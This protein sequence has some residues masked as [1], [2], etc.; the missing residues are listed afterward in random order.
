METTKLPLQG[1]LKNYADDDEPIR[2]VEWLWLVPLAVLQVILVPFMLLYMLC[3]GAV[4]RVR[5]LLKSN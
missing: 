1:N 4:Q 3:A 5:H 2:P